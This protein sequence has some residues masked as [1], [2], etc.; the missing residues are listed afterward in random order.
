MS[1]LVAW[2][3]IRI[4]DNSFMS[5]AVLRFGVVASLMSVTHSDHSGRAC[6]RLPT[7]YM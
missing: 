1:G 5:R 6:C 3:T 4:E 2:D 7:I